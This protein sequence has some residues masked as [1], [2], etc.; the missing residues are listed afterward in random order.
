WRGV[1][2]HCDVQRQIIVFFTGEGIDL[3]RHF[4][5]ENLE[6]ILSKSGNELAPL[7]EHRDRQANAAYVDDLWFLMTRFEGGGL[8]RLLRLRLLVEGRSCRQQISQVQ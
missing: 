2:Q 1:H 8:D 5:F 4:V 6:V 3:L 7:I